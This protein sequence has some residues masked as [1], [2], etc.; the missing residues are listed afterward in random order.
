MKLSEL[1]VK[2]RKDFPKDEVSVS[3]QLLIR[4]GFIDKL[5]AGVYTLLPLGLR[6]TSKI[7]DIIRDE[8]EKMG[9]SEILM[10]SLVPKEKWE[11][12]GRWKSFG[13]LYRLQGADEKEYGLGATHE[14][15]VVP[16]AKNFI[17]SYRDLPTGLYQIQNKFRDETRAKSGVLRTREFIMYDLY[18][19]H[20]DKKDLERYYD[21]AKEVFGKIFARC[22]IKDETYYTFA[23][24]GS[25]AKYSH[26]FQTKTEAGEDEVYVCKK[27]QTGLNREILDGDFKCP[28]CDS[29]EY[30][31]IKA[32]EV[33]NIFKLNDKYSR[34]FDLTF[35]DKDGQDKI[36][37]MGCYGIGVQRLMGT[38]V[39][40]N[41]DK[42]G[43][44]W[45][46]EVAPYRI[47]LIGLEGREKEAE[48]LYGKLQEKGVEVL[49]DDRDLSAGEKFADCDLLGIPYRVV[50]SKKTDGKF[51]LKK[52]AQKDSA[53]VDFNELIAQVG[54]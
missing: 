53:L 38:I 32:V 24:G 7:S 35:T 46:E 26:E 51:E 48:T 50:I 5:T 34:P 8:T 43:M 11:A 15:V 16:L 3:S 44:I 52:R 37:L 49:L 6:T 20:A 13:A 41:R 29:N 39:E 27:C 21:K 22:G 42:D 25:F 40:V 36:V 4:A 54:S 33:G 28:A 30:D 47:Y 10:P 18:S 19:F 1:V 17:S 23:S 2:T 14:E 31:L 45:P 12:T 9:A